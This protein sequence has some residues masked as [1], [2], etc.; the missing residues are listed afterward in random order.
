VQTVRSGGKPVLLLGHARGL[1][2]S[3]DVGST[4]QRI[5]V[6]GAGDLA[7]QSL[8]PDA[9]HGEKVVARTWN[10]LF[11]SADAGL[12]WTRLSSPVDVSWIH[13]AAIESGPTGPI[14]LATAEGLYRTE[15]LDGPWTLC[16]NGLPRETVNTVRYHPERRGEAYAVSYGRL[17]R[18]ADS[19]SIWQQ[20]EAGPSPVADI[21]SLWFAPQSP[22]RVLAVTADLGVM[23]LDLA[24]T[25]QD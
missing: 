22:D 10:N 11:Y 14:L 12:S 20:V 9:G 6:D 4:W 7:V 24:E 2:R 15:S 19:G 13:D 1:Y 16:N 18:S 8:F 3:T 5:A 25:R 21:R 23:F 17:Y